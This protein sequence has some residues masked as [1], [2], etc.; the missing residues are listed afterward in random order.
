M[1]TQSILRRLVLLVMVMTG[2]ALISG[3]GGGGSRDQQWRAAN[4]QP[5]AAD[6]AVDA[7]AQDGEPPVVEPRVVL[8]ATADPGPLAD[9]DPSLATRFPRDM[10]KYI[11]SLVDFTKARHSE[12]LPLSG[13]EEWEAG[14]LS[15]LGGAHVGVTTVVEAVTE[16]RTVTPPYSQMVATVRMPAFHVHG[17]EVWHKTTT[18]SA[19]NEKRPKLSNPGAQPASLAAWRA[20]RKGVWSLSRHLQS[21]SDVR[22]DL[23]DS[24]DLDDLSLIDVTFDSIPPNADIYVDGRFRGTTPFVV[25]IPDT[26]VEVVLRRQGYQ[27]WST[28]LRPEVNMAIKPVMESIAE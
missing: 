15:A 26:E 3:C 4:P 8:F 14:P 27:P 2:A 28:T 23:A 21:L 17:K 22:N 11:H 7:E 1:N 19:P 24:D 13:S 18:G 20:A 10:T 5:E 9:E 16:E 12:I 25:P 6:D